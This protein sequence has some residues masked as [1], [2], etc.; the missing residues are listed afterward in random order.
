[1]ISKVITFKASHQNWRTWG[2]SSLLITIRMQ[3]L[4]RTVHS[5]REPQRYLL[6]K[7]KLENSVKFVM[8]S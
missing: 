6:D 8:Y 5:I 3:Y 4:V 7:R 1:M 2:N